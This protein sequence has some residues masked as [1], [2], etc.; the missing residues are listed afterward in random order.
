MDFATA[1]LH[2]RILFSFALVEFPMIR[3]I[4][5]PLD[6]STFGEHA[7][8]LAA[9]LARRAGATLHLVHVH[10]VIPPAT[11]AGLTVMDSLD[12][13]LRQDEQAYLADVKRR[14]GEKGPIEVRPTLI[15]GE[16]SSA[17][18]TYAAKVE[19]DLVVMS[20]HG[21]GALGRFWLGSVAD[22]L[23]RHFP[24]PVLLVRPHEGKPDLNRES[25]LSNIVVSLDGSSLA[26]QV[27]EPVMELGKLFGSSF[28]LVRV[29]RPVLR[30]SYL[31]DGGTVL[32]LEHSALEELHAVQKHAVDDARAYLEGIA[33]R[34]RN[35]GFTAHTHAVIDEEPATAILLEARAQHAGL[36]AMETHGR[37]GLSRLFKGSIADKVVRVTEVPVLLNRPAG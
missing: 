31:P 16:V 15:E 27:L 24:R 2:L 36:I 25:S 29:V 37:S 18:Q 14:L 19:A 4:L 20:A 23:V 13:H 3:S 22:D 35:K 32:G 33:S 21:R 28:T 7:L 6:G 17:L 12:L 26:E 5:A 11:I 9:T 8:P 34:V 30:P 1:F 10:Q